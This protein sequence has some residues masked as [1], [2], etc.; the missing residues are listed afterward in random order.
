MAIQRSFQTALLF[1]LSTISV[2]YG[3]VVLW[4]VPTQTSLPLLCLLTNEDLASQGEGVEIRDVSRMQECKGHSPEPGDVLVEVAGHRVRSFG[5]FVKVHR[6]LRSV[7]IGSEAQLQYG[8]DPTEISDVSDL[9]VVEYPDRSRYVKVWFRPPG[10]DVPVASWLRL[11]PEPI[12]DVSIALVWF[13]LQTC[14]IVIAGL[15][16]WHRPFDQPVR[17]FFAL[18]TVTLCAYLGGNHWWVLSGSFTLIELFAISGILLPAVLL[19]FAVVYPA[20]KPFYLKHRR[21]TLS[22]IYGFPVLAALVIGGLIFVTWMLSTDFGAGPFAETLQRLSGRVTADLLPVLRQCVFLYL[23]VGIVYFV[24]SIVALKHSLDH[25]RTPLE[26]NQVQPILRAGLLASVPVGYTAFLAMTAP[27]S[28]ALGAARIPMFLAGLAFMLA[29][30]IGIA[31]YKLFLPEQVVGRGVWYYLASTALAIIFSALIAVGA[32]TALHGDLAIFGRTVPL[33]MVL[34]LAVLMLCWARDILQRSLDR[35]FFREKY[36][37]DKALQRMNRVAASVLDTDA[38]SESLLNSCR[39]VLQVRDAALYLRRGERLLFRLLTAQGTETRPLQVRIEDEVHQALE[40]DASLQKVPSSG[41]PQQT[42]IRKL[43]AELL[44]G[45]ELDGQ[46]TGLLVLGPKASGAAFTA[47][48]VAFVAAMGRIS[49][50][51]LQCAKVH[52]EFARVNEDLKLKIER[53]EEQDR[54]LAQLQNELATLSR[55]QPTTVPVEDTFLRDAIKGQSPAIRQVLDTVKKVSRSDASVLIRGESGTGK[56]LLA[57][58]IHENSPRKHGPMISVHCAALAPT[59]LESELFGHVKGA[60]TDA[61]EAKVGRFALAHG[62]TLFLDEIGDISLDVQVKLLRVLQERTFE[63]VGSTGSQTVDVRV[64]A[65]THRDLEQLIADGQFRQDLYYRLNVI[66]VWVPSL[67]ERSED[68][69]ELALHFLHA[70]AK[71]AGK[72][73]RLFDDAAL[74]ALTNYDWPGNI[75]ELQNAIERAVVLA[76]GERIQVRDLPAE[77]VSNMAPATPSLGRPPRTGNGPAKQLSLRRQTVTPNDDDAE[78]QQLV[79]ALDACGGNKAEAA[80]SLG[81]PRSTFFSKLKKYGLR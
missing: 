79:D 31:R 21:T 12:L 58:A 52:E 48:D 38:V 56:E 30:G 55:L 75:R 66:S 2:G 22:L 14:V 3:L 69:L 62:G 4:Y 64:L 57:R 41:S 71:K 5:D 27:T 7:S 11:G 36:Q 6:D 18:S 67:R 43:S 16:Y 19:H 68:I 45:I 33:V 28:F 42:L 46:L 1:I 60:F 23:G 15:A 47:E 39:D 24:L 25:P 81:M 17:T 51:A 50:V 8:Q 20:A 26:Q 10:S 54:Q 9:A 80:R 72:S 74:N 59:L 44:H 77:I 35:R 65:A 53:I 61:H 78:M 76:D 40:H 13:V 70:A 37:L 29:Y 63:P 32:V 73:V 34:M 49:A